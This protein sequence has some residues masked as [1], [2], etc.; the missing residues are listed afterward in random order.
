M[1]RGHGAEGAGLSGRA[2]ALRR[3][4]KSDFGLHDFLSRPDTGLLLK[5]AGTAIELWQ[6]TPGNKAKPPEPQPALPTTR[7]NAPPEPVPATGPKPWSKP[8]PE[9]SKQMIEFFYPNGK[10]EPY[11]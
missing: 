8:T 9:R 7:S 11:C 6:H 4:D 1:P 10:K 2:L 3:L 5:H